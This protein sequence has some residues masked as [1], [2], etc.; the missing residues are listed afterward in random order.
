ML[1]LHPEVDLKHIDRLA[2][3]PL[4]THEITHLPLHNDMLAFP[5]P[6]PSSDAFPPPPPPRLD[7]LNPRHARVDARWAA[8]ESTFAGVLRDSEG[9][10]CPLPSCGEYDCQIH[11]R[12]PP[13][14][15]FQTSAL[16]RM[17]C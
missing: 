13:P 10:F 15:P 3:L 17:Q 6:N 5:S 7:G 1:L 14:S 2:F 4:T 16:L 8:G 11:S 9:M 12:S